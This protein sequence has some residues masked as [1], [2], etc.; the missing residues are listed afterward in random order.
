MNNAKLTALILSLSGAAMSQSSAATYLIDFSKFAEP[1]GNWNSLSSTDNSNVALVDS[2]GASNGVTISH[3]LSSD[4]NISGGWTIGNA[5]WVDS[6]AASDGLYSGSSA[7]ITILGLGSPTSSYSIK[8]VAAED[9]DSGPGA[10]TSVADFRVQGSFADGNRL[11]T[12]ANGDNWNSK[13][14]GT[15]NFLI[16][17]N[18]NPN[19]S[20]QITIA[21]DASASGFTTINAI[22]VSLT[23]EPTSTALLGFGSLTLLMRRKRS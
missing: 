9:G 15:N 20:G 7:A 14:D 23:P 13:T 22:E 4:S 5:D 10:F 8:I 18:V 19:A 3:T 2:T 6:A 1:T 11:G 12:S 21:I 17:N 16:W